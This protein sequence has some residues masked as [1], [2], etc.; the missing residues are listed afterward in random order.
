[1]AISEVHNAVYWKVKQMKH[2]IRDKKEKIQK[3][4]EKEALTGASSLFIRQP[5]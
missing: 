1:M 5:N 4:C 3:K 2:S